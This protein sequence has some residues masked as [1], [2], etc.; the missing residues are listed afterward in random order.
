MEAYARQNNMSQEEIDLWYTTGLLHD[1]DYEKFPTV[2]Q[3]AIEGVKILAEKGYPT[4]MT[5]AI[6]S[7][8]DYGGVARE[9]PMQKTLFAVDE[10]SGF[11]VALA[12]VRQDN[13]ETMI[14]D[15][16]EKALKKKQFAAAVSREDIDKGAQ[17]LGI[18][19]AE[20]FTSVINALKEKKAFLGF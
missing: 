19:R 20:H 14:A 18:S 11:I 16:V 5:Q 10:L 12:K 13:F 9:T 3:H 4:E 7:H 6:L 17:L 2:P 1:F 8:V 15:S